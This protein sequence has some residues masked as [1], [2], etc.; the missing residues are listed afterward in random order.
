MALYVVINEEDCIGCEVCAEVCPTTPCVF[1]MRDHLAVVVHDEECEEC[2]LCVETCPT[3][4]VSM[5][6]S[7][8][9]QDEFEQP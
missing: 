3:N 7:A 5:T 2:M 9:A 8:P 1:E 4:A 6:D